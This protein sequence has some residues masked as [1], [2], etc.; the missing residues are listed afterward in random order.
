MLVSVQDVSN[1]NFLIGKRFAEAILTVLQ[2]KNIPTSQISLIGSHGNPSH[3]K[4]IANII[5]KDKLFGMK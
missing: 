2:K 4:L 1:A 3:R 5:L